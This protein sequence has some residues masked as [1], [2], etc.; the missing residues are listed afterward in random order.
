MDACSLCAQTYMDRKP[1]VTSS[2]DNSMSFL[3]ARN[4]SS[5]LFLLARFNHHKEA[6]KAVLQLINFTNQKT[7]VRDLVDWNTVSKSWSPGLNPGY[8]TSESGLS[9]AVSHCSFCMGMVM[10]VLL[11][12]QLGYC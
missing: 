9:N 6:M 10:L 8:L 12:Y 11:F 5:V 3:Q 2:I 1:T 7:E 4:F